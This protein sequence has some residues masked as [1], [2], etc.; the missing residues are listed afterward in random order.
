MSLVIGNVPIFENYFR[1]FED[2]D[3]PSLE[4]RMIIS[5]D[6]AQIEIE[7]MTQE[8]AMQEL[9][10]AMTDLFEPVSEKPDTDWILPQDKIQKF[11][12]LLKF[13]KEKVREEGKRKLIEEKFEKVQRT[14]FTEK[15]LPD[16]LPV[17]QF[18]NNPYHQLDYIRIEQGDPVK[19]PRILS[20]MLAIRSYFNCPNTK[21]EDDDLLLLCDF[22]EIDALDGDSL[23]K[24]ALQRLIEQKKRRLDDHC[25]RMSVS[26]LNLR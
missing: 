22:S 17:L 16:L 14:I 12:G 19:F 11:A 23:R 9:K 1:S 3:S 4:K 26:I 5:V 6:G 10:T 18:Y 25:K 13:Y 20:L 21:I 24:L 8:E 2:P 15:D 7:G